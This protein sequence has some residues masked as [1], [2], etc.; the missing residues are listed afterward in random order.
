M[1]LTSC[2]QKSKDASQLN[3][4]STTMSERRFAEIRSDGDA[5]S[6]VAVRYG[7]TATIKMGSM[8]MRE[9]IEPGA[10]G[11]VGDV[12]LNLQHDRT[13]PIARTGEGGGLELTDTKE[14]LRARISAPSYPRWNE[15]TDLVNRRVLRGLSVEFT[16]PRGGEKVVE[17]GGVISRTIVSA[18]LR[19]IGLVDSPAYPDST[20]LRS[21]DEFHKWLAGHRMRIVPRRMIA[22]L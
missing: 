10:F 15:I 3:E 22:W 17:S 7:D 5:L 11:D 2:A 21:E 4:L 8:Q 19:A 16:V 14:S 18:N 1:C 13:Q 6:G 12:V 20:F 9:T